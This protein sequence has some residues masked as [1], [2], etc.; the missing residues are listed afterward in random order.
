MSDEKL[1]ESV[2]LINNHVQEHAGSAAERF[3]R[4]RPRSV[5]PNSIRREVHYRDLIRDRHRKQVALAKAKGRTSKDEFKTQDRVVIQCP[6]TRK[7]N[8]R[9]MITGSRVNEDG[10]VTTHNIRLDNG[11][12]TVR[13]KKYIKYERDRSEKKVSFQL[14]RMHEQQQSAEREGPVTRAQAKRRGLSLA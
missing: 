1:R 6:V 9:G 14:P 5:L 4:R 2:F 3:Y 8:Q 7:W 13:H 11:T 10:S 12:D